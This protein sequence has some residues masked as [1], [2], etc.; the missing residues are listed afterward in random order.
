[1]ARVNR[2]KRTITTTACIGQHVTELGEFADFVD[3][4]PKDVACDE[5]SRILRKKWDDES[6]VI[7]IVEPETSEYSMSVDEFIAAAHEKPLT[8]NN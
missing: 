8:R 3:V 2:I 5:A 7:N 4:I 1:M 6:I